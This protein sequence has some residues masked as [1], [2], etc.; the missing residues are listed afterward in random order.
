MLEATRN[1]NVWNEFFICT[2]IKPFLYAQRLIHLS[3]RLTSF[4]KPLYNFGAD[5]FPLTD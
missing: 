4:L 2:P 3:E 1:G 5:T